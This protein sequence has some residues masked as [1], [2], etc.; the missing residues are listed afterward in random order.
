ML[1]GCVLASRRMRDQGHGDVALDA[2]HSRLP[3]GR[4][5]M[6]A[7]KGVQGPI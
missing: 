1:A 4:R 6:L 5:M 3:G 2:G 7:H